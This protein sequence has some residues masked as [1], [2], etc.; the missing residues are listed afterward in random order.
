[1]KRTAEGV[2]LP[3]GIRQRHNGAFLVDVTVDGVRKTAVVQSLEE[4]IERRA[5]LT[6]NIATHGTEADARAIRAGVWTLQQAYDR[7][8]AQH[9]SGIPSEKT[10]E[11][12]ATAALEFFGRDTL[13]TAVNGDRLDAYVEYLIKKRGNSNATINRKLSALSKIL[14][15]ARERGH[16]TE[17]PR[18]ARR[19]ERIGRIR[20]LTV[21][22]E[23]ALLQWFAHIGMPDHREAIIILI[24]TG[25]RTGELWRLE[26]RDV[27]LTRGTITLWVTK[28]KKPRTIPMTSRVREII[29]ARCQL[30]PSGQLFPGSSKPWMRQQWDHVRALMQMVHDQDFVPHMLRHTCC[31]RLVQRGVPLTHVQK[32]MGHSDIK[33]TMRYAHLAPHDLFSAVAVLEGGDASRWESSIAETIKAE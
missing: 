33:T 20:F 15:T 25:F 12:N 22:E 28:S 11:I 27:D 13:V 23:A 2:T 7:T 18:L 21:T 31:S 4:A 24:D 6:A 19:Q 5:V 14:A 26:A 17:I 10:N 1:M 30:Y 29:T 9:W 16:V 32:W 8:H 3:K